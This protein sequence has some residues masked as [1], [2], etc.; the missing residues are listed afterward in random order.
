MKK[1]LYLILFL[2]LQLACSVK[3]ENIHKNIIK[4]T[5]IEDG[6]Y[7]ATIEY[8]NYNTYTRS[9]YTL[10]VKVEDDR[11]VAI[12][13]EDGGYIHTGYNDYGYTYSGGYLDYE[14]NYNNQITEA[15]TKVTLYKADGTIV[16]FDITIE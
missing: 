6:V 15:T 14:T 1:N 5:G 13:F 10:N 4:I 7:S 11:V 9:T 8:F 16:T 3:A 2:I 12:Y